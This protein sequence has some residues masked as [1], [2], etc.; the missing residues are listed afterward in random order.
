MNMAEAGTEFEDIMD[1]T[2]DAPG[3]EGDIIQE[4]Q[5]ES[6]PEAPEFEEVPERGAWTADQGDD[7]AQGAGP[8]AAVDESQDEN[9]GENGGGHD[10]E[11]G[12]PADEPGETPGGTPGGTPGET[13]PAAQSEL[14]IVIRVQTGRT[15][16]GVTLTE[17]DPHMELLLDDDIGMIA[18]ELPGIIERAR[19]VW[20]GQ[21]RG[22]AWKAPAKP[23]A[24]PKKT[25]KPKAAKGAP[26]GRPDAEPPAEPEPRTGAE[27]ETE[28]TA[29]TA[30]EPAA[31]TAVETA[32]EP[33]LQ[34]QPKTEPEPQPEPEAE[35][36]P[37][38]AAEGMETMLEKPEPRTGMVPMF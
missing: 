1:Q 38:P 26:T 23:R 21:P 3:P 4:S 8:N 35:A 34:I 14:K 19:E 29:E 5:P 24:K 27:I 28:N 36:E 25:S 6:Q 9:G 32:V 37:E 2:Q 18:G 16:V 7:P 20:Q 15:H 11:T 17:T 31:Q 22:E 30:V 33:E 12:V 10:E 13:E